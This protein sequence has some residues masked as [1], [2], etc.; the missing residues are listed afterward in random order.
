MAEGANEDFA[1]ILEALRE[2]KDDLTKHIDEKTADIQATLTK[3]EASLSTLAEQVQEMETRVATNEDDIKEMRDRVGSMEKTITQ[4]WEKNDDL[5]NCNRRSNIRILNIPEQAE[6]RD[7]V[8]FLERLLPQMLGPDNFTSAVTLERA[9]RIGKVSDRPRAFIAKFLNLRDKEKVLRLARNKG[10]ITYDNNRIYFFPDYS[11]ELQRRRD[12]FLTIKRKLR[13]KDVEY[14]LLYPAK[15][16]VK[17]NGSVK[18]F[19]SP[20]EAEG[21]LKE[22][23]TE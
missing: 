1:K 6:G 12:D 16:R 7:A 5:E 11:M 13:E 2:N 8:G 3:I 4:L 19:S 20:V 21:F 10:E 15:L 9:H 22:L 18:F 17:Y 23:V 14:A